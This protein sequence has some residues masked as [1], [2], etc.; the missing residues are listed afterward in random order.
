MRAAPVAL[1]ASALYTTDVIISVCVC[2]IGVCRSHGFAVV[3]NVVPA[4]DLAAINAWLDAHPEVPVLDTWERAAG[5]LRDPAKRLRT[6]FQDPE[7]E[8]FLGTSPAP[9]LQGA[10]GRWDFNQFIDWS[11]ANCPFRALVSNPTIV[12]WMLGTIGDEFRFSGATGIVQKQGS[13]G[14]I[15]HGKGQ[16]VRPS[17]AKGFSRAPSNWYRFEGGRFSNGL[18]AVNIALTDVNRGDGGFM[19]IA[20]S[21]K[22]ELQVPLEVRRM[23]VD[24]GMV[25]Q[26]PMKAGSALFFSEALCHG[27]L[28]WVATST[29]R[30]LIY[31]YNPSF[32]V[33]PKGGMDA[34]Q[35]T[36]DQASA[37]AALTGGLTELELA[38]LEPA[39]K[40]GDAPG[41]P[42]GRP[43]IGR[44]CA[45][46]V[47]GSSVYSIARL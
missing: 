44:M 30:A 17:G 36:L 9:A 32:L 38:L 19:C 45:K 41:M 33:P 42:G 47:E 26:I 6:A 13:E 22:A 4:A 11:R 5:N 35:A 3:E 39:W 20:G 10:H 31:R 14:F 37:A 1:S 25:Q 27:T 23:D 40:G 29:R 15:M 24:L 12:R 7:D 8:R 34:Q 21:H 16:Y 43:N 46:P 28:P 2:V 18:M